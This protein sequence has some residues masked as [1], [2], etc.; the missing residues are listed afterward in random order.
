MTK[1][2]RS[3]V[4]R[5]FLG[6]CG[7]IGDA[8]GMDSNVLR[9]LLVVSMFYSLGVTVLGYFVA[10][11]CLSPSEVEVI[12]NGIRRL[13]RS[14]TNRKLFGVCGG[15]AQYFEVDAFFVRML[16][17]ILICF[18]GGGLLMYIVFACIVPK[19]PINNFYCR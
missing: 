2:F 8:L 11:F 16:F 13:Y 14:R 6:V 19:E 15:I 10:A 12:D 1:F 7:G 5:K 18:L 4:N 9:V 3:R 17:L